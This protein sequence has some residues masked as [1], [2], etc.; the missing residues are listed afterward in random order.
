MVVAAVEKGRFYLTTHPNVS[1]PVR[2]RMD[3]ILA[4]I[5]G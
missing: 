3:K 1:G 2:D 4:E 5:D